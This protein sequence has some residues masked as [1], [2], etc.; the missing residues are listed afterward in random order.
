MKTAHTADVK[1]FAIGAMTLRP[2]AGQ[3][4]MA[5]RVEAPKGA[6]APA[7]SHP[8]EQMTLVLSGRVRFRVGDEWQELGPMDIVHIPGGVEHEAIME[9]DSL[10]FDLFHPVRTDFLERQEAA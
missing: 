5:V 9:E 4:L 3:E 2:F 10:F 1:S 8:H 6:V 7:H